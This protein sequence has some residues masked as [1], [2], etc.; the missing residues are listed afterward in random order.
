MCRR[1]LRYRCADT[2]SHTKVFHERGYIT[3]FIRRN[4]RSH[5]HRIIRVKKGNQTADSINAGQV[6]FLA[7]DRSNVKPVGCKHLS[8]LV[9]KESLHPQ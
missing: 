4:A 6:Q 3:A 8:Q 1:I 9:C 2:F 5:D 7:P